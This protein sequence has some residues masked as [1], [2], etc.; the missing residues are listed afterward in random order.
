MKIPQ[1]MKLSLLAGAVVCASSVSG[2]MTLVSDTFTLDDGTGTSGAVL[3]N[4]AAEVYNDSGSNLWNTTVSAGSTKFSADGTIIS[5]SDNTGF[6]ARIEISAPT[7]SI[8]S[9]SASVRAL[10]SDWVAIGFAPD[11][12]D[13]RQLYTTGQS[14]IWVYLR[15][16]GTMEVYSDGTQNRLANGSA[17]G[18]GGGFDASA[19]YDLTL[20]YDPLNDLAKV[21]VTDASSNTYTI[22]WFS[23]GTLN[24]I[25]AAAIK[26]NSKIVINGGTAAGSPQIDSF[27]V[28]VIP[29]PAHA[30]SLIGLLA[31]ACLGMARTRKSNN[32]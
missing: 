5:S 16:S 26:M 19:F 8:M 2:Q 25:G 6:E 20:N 11:A 28:T 23:T 21:T 1:M 17:S 32:R 27:E 15:P 18:L 3:D 13:G 14:S 31:L 24:S 7:T 9:V 10:D 12:A 29:E 22:D 4:T 30:A